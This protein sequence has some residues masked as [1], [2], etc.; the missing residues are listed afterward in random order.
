MKI[1][2][3]QEI[4]SRPLIPIASMPRT[5]NTYTHESMLEALMETGTL[6]GAAQ[7]LGITQKKLIVLLQDTNVQGKLEQMRWERIELGYDASHDQPCADVLE[8]ETRPHGFTN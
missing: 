8:G 3:G 4:P 7:L 1:P 2:I 5:T 6:A